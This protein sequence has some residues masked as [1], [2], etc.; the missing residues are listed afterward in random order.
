MDDDASIQHTTKPDIK[1][2]IRSR[3]WNQLDVIDDLEFIGI[4]THVDVISERGSP[5][6]VT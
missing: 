4:N 2:S 6:P 3:I 1:S 5:S